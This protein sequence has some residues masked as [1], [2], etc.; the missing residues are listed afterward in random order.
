MINLIKLLFAL[1]W[2]TFL[3]FIVASLITG[4]SK[5][6]SGP[7]KLAYSYLLG[8]GSLTLIIL[9]LGLCRVNLT[10]PNI[11]IG[12]AI[13]LAVPLY[14]AIKNE[15]LDFG[16][17]TKPQPLTRPETLLLALI[18]LR[19]AFVLFENLIKPVIGVDAFANWS[20]RAKVFFVDGGLLLNRTG[21]Y[22]LGGG[23]TFYPL[24]IPLLQTWIYAVLG[25]W[26]D[27]LAK[28]IFGC[29]FVALIMLF[30]GTVRRSAPRFVALLGT[31][32]LTTLPFLVFHATIEYADL[33]LAIYYCASVFLL[34]NYFESGDMGALTLSAL[35][36]G[37]GTWSKSEGMPL[38]L[39][40][41]GMLGLFYLRSQVK[42]LTAGKQL[43]LYLGL[44]LLFKAPWSLIN[45]AYRIPKNIYQQVHW[46]QALANLSRLPVIAQY[47]YQKMFFY[48]NW[49][50]AWF[51]L[52]IVALLSWPRLKKGHP[53][54]SLLYVSLL[55]AM[56]AFMYYLTDNYIWL[57]DGT[58]LNRNT[59]LIV[60]LVIYFITVNLPALLA[61]PPA[62]AAKPAKRKN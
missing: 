35:L 40:N 43:A 29:F 6:L 17:W 15:I 34:L 58:T 23:Q 41:C 42:P 14:L 36:G 44:A 54:Y 2:P 1:A 13:I 46:D 60:P 3:G 7:E 18:T 16:P 20:L 45:I 22:F 48:G 62:A 12:S 47:F 25:H 57:L 21:E 38:L 50:L 61:P 31:Y 49:N 55:L 19:S 9:L 28:V 33:P 59:L 24:N 27:A 53:F 10:G 8:C 11:I 52:V 39:V 26:D 4:R 32:L 5:L 51:T 56:F 37:V 30:Y